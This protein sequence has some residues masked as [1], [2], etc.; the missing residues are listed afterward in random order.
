MVT[1]I[2]LGHLL[3]LPD[4]PMIPSDCLAPRV[5]GA[6]FPGPSVFYPPPH[7]HSH[8]HSCLSSLRLALFPCPGFLVLDPRRLSQKETRMDPAIHT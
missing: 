3:P 5:G 7:A 4:T 8:F 6:A 1:R 2:Y